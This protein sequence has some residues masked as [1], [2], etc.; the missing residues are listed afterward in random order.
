[1][2]TLIRSDADANIGMG[3]VI[4]SLALADALLDAGHHVTWL[5]RWEPASLGA[6]IRAAGAQ[7]IASAATPG[8]SDD[9]ALTLSHAAQSDW[10]LLDGYGFGAEFLQ[11]VRRTGARVFVID[12]APR[13][14]YYDVDVLLDQNLHSSAPEYRVPEEG[15]LLLG[16]RYALLRSQFGRRPAWPPPAPEHAANILVT[17]GGSDPKGVTVQVLKSLANLSSPTKAAPLHIRVVVGPANPR[18][19]EIKAVATHRT[20]N[21][22]VLI[23][24]E[25]MCAL[26]DWAHVAI[27][28]A[29]ST[30]WELAC[31][32]V[33]MITI[34][35]A[36]NQVPVAEGLARV[37]ASLNLGDAEQ[38]KPEDIASALQALLPDPLRRS[39][40]ARR[41]RDVV[42]GLGAFRVA[43][44]L[45]RHGRP[46]ASSEVSIRPANAGDARLLWNWA[47]DRSVRAVSFRKDPIPWEAHKDWFA[48]R[49]HSPDVRIWVLENAGK[50]VGQ[51]RYERT[52][53]G[54][55]AILNFSV[56]A[57]QRGK[58]YGEYLVNSTKD[59]ALHELNVPQI[60]ALVLEEN[61]A[62]ANV[63]IRAG[64]WFQGI[65][66]DTSSG[67]R[68]RRFIFREG[69][70]L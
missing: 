42:D 50:P 56:A 58:G 65:E 39:E 60:T 28:A 70:E 33:P 32:G 8:G 15:R 44:V 36:P 14:P 53:D 13:L 3:H 17:M 38:V 21:V 23:A 9:L 1:M 43:K 49:L 37:G 2:R 55:E 31:V 30:C 41:G 62:S 6:R 68:C 66:T 47:N 40:M 63:F 46:A 59:R 64:Y 67:S 18:T 48:R 11:A 22:E 29:G 54:K 51:I 24:V 16:P 7:A 20:M 26:M 35:T 19:E 45:T 4:R 52:S 69:D 5:G 61:A 57:E 25:D 10:V 27:T 34:V 12:D